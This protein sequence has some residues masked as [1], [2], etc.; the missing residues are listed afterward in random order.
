ML[1]NNN[2]G[3]VIQTGKNL[4]SNEEYDIHFA[5]VVG[6]TYGDIVIDNCMSNTHVSADNP[7]AITYSYNEKYTDVNSL[8]VMSADNNRGRRVTESAHNDNRNV[9]LFGSVS[10]IENDNRVHTLTDDE[11]DDT[12]SV[13]ITNTY[14]LEVEDIPS[15]NI[16]PERDKSVAVD[17]GEKSLRETA[18][19]LNQSKDERYKKWSVDDGMA[20][21][22]DEDNPAV[23]KV[24]IADDIE[25]GTIGISEPSGYYKAG[26]RV[27]L[28]YDRDDNC[29]FVG[30]T[31]VEANLVGG[32]WEFI[33]PEKD[34]EI[35]ACFYN[36]DD[37]YMYL[38]S[39]ADENDEYTLHYGAMH[40]AYKLIIAGYDENNALES[41]QVVECDEPNNTLKVKKGENKKY[42]LWHTINGMRPLC[43]AVTIK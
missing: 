16:S 9:S 29:E 23:Y 2:N 24:T 17:Y 14:Y 42:M 40:I 19:N 26:E 3:Y 31:G 38:S 18:Y 22:A 39:S 33:M 35:G 13:R 30:F 34:V 28:W 27:S 20:I 5:G 32:V 8:S 21:F 25:N 37:G 1:N 7:Y 10:D 12:Y 15:S 43:D 11:T 41:I 6:Y 36:V 4:D